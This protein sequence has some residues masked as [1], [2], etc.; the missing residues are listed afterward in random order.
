MFRLPGETLVKFMGLLNLTFQAN[1]AGSESLA[2]G[3]NTSDAAEITKEDY[4]NNNRSYGFIDYQYNP[5]NE[6]EYKRFLRNTKIRPA[7]FN[8][9]EFLEVE[10]KDYMNAISC[11]RKFFYNNFIFPLRNDKKIGKAKKLIN[12]YF[13]FL[14]AVYLYNQCYP[15]AIG[16]YSNKDFDEKISP[17]EIRLYKILFESCD[18]LSCPHTFYGIDSQVWYRE[19]FQ[20]LDKTYLRQLILATELVWLFPKLKDMFEDLS[21]GEYIN[22][23]LP[24]LSGSQY[25]GLLSKLSNEFNTLSSFHLFN[26]SYSLK[27]D[28]LTHLRSIFKRKVLLYNDSKR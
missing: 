7:K 15:K 8:F 27:H 25:N 14:E 1:P 22:Y 17:E 24:R 2:N 18:E 5:L 21:K 12:M 11:Y 16:F 26:K 23:R 6:E 13:S 4:Y 19:N 9:E 3:M 28:F 10:S 20:E